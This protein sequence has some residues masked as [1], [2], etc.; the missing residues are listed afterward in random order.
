[1]KSLKEENIGNKIFNSRE[2]DYKNFK[3]TFFKK[4]TNIGKQNSLT[5]T[6][7]INIT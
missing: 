7:Q 1:M 5:I 2:V 3:R 4:L 6:S